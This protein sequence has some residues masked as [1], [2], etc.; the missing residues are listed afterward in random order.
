[1][2]EVKLNNYPQFNTCIISVKTFWFACIAHA[3]IEYVSRSAI[4]VLGSNE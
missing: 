4:I 3:R 1:M 2:F